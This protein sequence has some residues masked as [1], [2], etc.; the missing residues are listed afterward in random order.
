MFVDVGQE[1]Q[2]QATI[3]DSTGGLV[4]DDTV[5]VSIY[6]TRRKIY[7]N[8]II[9]TED[10]CEITMPHIGSGVYSFVF[11]PETESIF[12]LT[13]RATNN[14]Y[15]Q[16]IG[17]ESMKENGGIPIKIDSSLFLNQDG[18]NSILLDINSNPIIGVKISCYNK[19]TKEIIGVSQSNQ[20]GEWSMMIPQGTYFFTFEKD[21]FIS[22]SFERT[23]L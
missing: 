8:G 3:T 17:I 4:G 6:D 10:E 12:S 11:V 7:F 13:I 22:V 20:T 16:I 23:V 14:I 9:W 1:Y 2:V 18:T 5:I 15:S 19:D 21:G